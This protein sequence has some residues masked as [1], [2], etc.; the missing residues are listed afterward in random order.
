MRKLGN[1]LAGRTRD[2]L[3][4]KASKE[5]KDLVDEHA[6]I[7]RRERDLV[8]LALQVQTSELEKIITNQTSLADLP[9]SYISEPSDRKPFDSAPNK[10]KLFRRMGMMGNRSLDVSYAKQTY[11][12]PDN[13]DK[14]VSSEMVTQLSQLVPVFRSLSNKHRDLILWQLTV[15]ENGTTAIYPEIPQIP[16]VRRKLRMNWYQVAKDRKQIVWSKPEID[17]ITNQIVFIV[18]APFFQPDDNVIGATAIVVPVDTLLKEDEHIGKLS[19]NITSLLARPERHTNSDRLGIR[20]IARE[21]IEKTL[22]HHWQASLSEEWL[23]IKDAQSIDQVIKDLQKKTTGVREVSFLGQQSLLAYG[24]ID[25]YQT[26]LLV[27]VPK[28]DIVAEAVSMETY[29]LGQIAN[30]IKVTSIILA[31]VIGAVILIALILSRSVTKSISRL[32]TAAQQVANGD[33]ST[34]VKIHSRDEMGELGHTFNDMVPALEERVKMKQALNLAMEVQ[35]NLLPKKI[36]RL[37]GIDI[38]GQ[39]IYCDETGGDY[40]DFL[41]VGRHNGYQLGVAVGDVSG[42]GIQAALLMAT[43]RAFLKSRVKQSGS[44]ADAISDINRLVAEDA[45]ETGQFMTLFYAEIEPH[46]KGL[47]WV[48]AGHDPALLYSPERETF[49]ELKGKGIALGIDSGSDYHGQTISGL[50]QGQVL[51]IGTDGIWETQNESGEMFGKKRLKTLIKQNAHLS[52]AEI[53][54]SIIKRLQSFRE[55]RRQ[56]D[57]ITLVVIKIDASHGI[58]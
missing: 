47:R 19:E 21:Q 44:I 14:K 42:H 7:L 9:N 30:L 11:W 8:E 26:A 34:R 32:A 53:I 10:R 50:S 5:L 27:I 15:F 22:H 31:V 39:S 58:E 35:Q 4:R 52:S 41:E 25:D 18:S 51:L 23:D 16:M 40:Y 17:P 36:P 1:D 37:P 54:A 57:D 46:G 24:S 55:S 38:A 45:S 28:V 49:E 12:I 29:V 33:F 43:V 2:V 48:R 13:L 6:T 3:V 20:I 56:A